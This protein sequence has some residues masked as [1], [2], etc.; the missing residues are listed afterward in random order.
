MPSCD[1]LRSYLNLAIRTLRRRVGYTLVN[2][3]GLTIGL[4][5]CAVIAVF[6]QYELSFDTHHDDANSIYRIYT[7]FE[8]NAFSDIQFPSF[9]QSTAEDQMVVPRRIAR[10]VPGVDDVA[11]FVILPTPLFVENPKGQRFESDRQLITNTGAAFG[12]M[13]TFSRIAGASV[14]KALS[15]P[16]SIV[17]TERTATKYFGDANPIG[18][19]LSVGSSTTATVR[20]VVEDPPMNTRIRFDLAL[21]VTRIPRWAAFRY[22]KLKPSVRPET[23]QPK[24]ATILNESSASLRERK[25]DGT[26]IGHFLQPLTSIHLADRMLYDRTPHRNPAY[27]WAFGAIGLLVLAITIINYA[28][29]ALAIYAGRNAEIGIRKALGGHRTQLARQFLVESSVLALACV[30]LAVGLCAAIIPGFNALMDTGISLWSVFDPI[31]LASLTVLALAAGLGAASYPAFVLAKKQTVNLFDHGFSTGTRKTWS[32]RHGLIALQFIVLIGLGGLSWIVYNQLDFMQNSDL[33][34]PVD[35]IVQLTSVQAD[36]TQY[37]Q[38]KR[39]MNESPHILAVGIGARPRQRLNRGPCGVTGLETDYSGCD[40]ER[41]DPD[42]FEVV[43]IDNAAV[44]RIREAGPSAPEQV[45]V[46]QAFAEMVS[47][48]IESP[49]GRGMINVPDRPPE[50]PPPIVG[51]IPNLHTNSMRHEIS[52]THYHV[53]AAPPYAYQPVMRI[54][55]G[56]TREAMAHAE[57]VLSDMFPNTPL[58]ISFFDDTVA[59]LYEQERR[60]GTLVTIL[61]M[62][63]IVLASIGLAGLVAYLTRMRMREIGIRKALGGSVASILVLLNREYVQLVAAGFVVGAPLAWWAGQMWLDQFAYQTSIS[64]WIFVATGVGAIMVA[65]AAVSTQAYR[66]ARVDPAHVLRSE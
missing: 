25:A 26:L 48:E 47:A 56:R 23:V 53:V 62:L 15:E 10:E 24:I 4:G 38:L 49:V 60:F 46:N 36:S 64:P 37:Q 19:T 27:L 11:Q 17:L 65:I 13:F 42:W 29:L 43:G 40:Y 3:V 28:N 6:L 59:E 41:V 39:R 61:S 63:A 58:E 54:A 20:S 30:P 22:V 55:S 32:L 12:R 45:V 35:T 9:N 31:V 44:E 14:E 1:M 34:Y 16:R 66:A 18:Q 2:V 52:P 5:C 57:A 8:D 33:G 21:S 50:T 7:Q 51:V